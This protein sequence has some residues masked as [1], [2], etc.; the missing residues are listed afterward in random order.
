[1]SRARVA[2]ETC[3]AIIKSGIRAIQMVHALRS[4][5]GRGNV[6]VKVESG[7]TERNYEKSINKAQGKVGKG[8]KRRVN[9]V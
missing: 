8:R 4:G 2:S 9:K 6:E 1:L 3:H 5:S 7:R